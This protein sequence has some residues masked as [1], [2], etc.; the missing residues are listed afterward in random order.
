MNIA[1]NS[2]SKTFTKNNT[3]L[4][5]QMTIYKKLVDFCEQNQLKDYFTGMP[6]LS[7]ANRNEF[8]KL[9]RE[10]TTTI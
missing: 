8:L 3:P 9:V 6:L 10:E 7:Y 1:S 5:D 2:I 4:N